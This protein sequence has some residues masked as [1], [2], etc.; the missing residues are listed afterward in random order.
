MSQ[1][2]RLR[3]VPEQ[4]VYAKEDLTARP[5]ADVPLSATT[6]PS[7]SIPKDTPGIYVGEALGEDGLV[8]VEFEYEKGYARVEILA[9]TIRT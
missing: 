8:I 6:P 7:Y 5:S 2:N 9:T 1:R 4:I 3:T